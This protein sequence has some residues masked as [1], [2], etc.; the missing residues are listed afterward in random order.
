LATNYSIISNL[1]TKWQSIGLLRF[2][3]KP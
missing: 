1:N 2:E 3:N